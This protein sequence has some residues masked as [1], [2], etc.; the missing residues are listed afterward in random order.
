VEFTGEQEPTCAKDANGRLWFAT[1]KG[2]AM[3]DPARLRLNSHPP[4]VTIEEVIY[5]A[6]SE[7]EAEQGKTERRAQAPFPERLDLPAG[8]RN[9]EIHY[10][11]PSFTSPEKVRFQTRLQSRGPQWRDV[12]NR[13]V[14][15][16]DELRPGQNLFQ[17]R[18]ANDDGVWN[19]TGASL[20]FGVAPLF[21][22]TAWFRALAWVAVG[23]ETVLVIAL[24][25]A[26]QRR[27]RAR[28]ELR[29]RLHFE[30]LI[31]QLSRVF[32]NL[33]S[34]KIEAQ[35]KEAL[36][37]VG[38][39]LKFDIAAFSTLRGAGLERR[40]S[41]LWRHPGV[42][43]V[44]CAGLEEELPWSA[45]ELTQGRDV[46]LPSISRL[47]P[48][49]ETDRAAYA[50][51]GVQSS[52]Q[53]PLYAGGTVLAAFSLCAVRERRELTREVLQRQRLIGE[54]FVNAL[55]RK[56]AEDRQRESEARFRI[57]AD[58]APVMIWMSGVDKLCTFFNKTWLDF[59]GRRLEQELG[60]GWAEG[61]HRADL[62]RCLQAYA[63]AF[64][65]RKPFVLQYRLRRN[66]GEYRWIADN[67]LPRFDTDGD[68][69]GYIGSCTDFTERKQA[70]EKFRLAVET[71]PN[72][73]LLVDEQGRIVMANPQTEAMFGYSAEEL[74]GQ[75]MEI[76]VPERFRGR[77]PAYRQEFHASP[78]TRAMGKGRELFARRKDGSE[79]EVEIALNP[80][81]AQDEMLVLATIVDVTERRRANLE[82]QTLRQELAHAG[83][84]SMM[85]QLASSL[86]HE[87]NQPLGAILRNAEAAELFLK[88]GN[89][90]L[91]EVRAILV[92]IQKDDH[93]AGDV[94]DRMRGLLSRRKLE[95]TPMNV[96]ELVDEV[97]ALIRPDAIHRR[98]H[99]SSEVPGNLGPVLVNRVHLQQVLLN[100]LLN[101][102]D[103]MSETPQ[104]E[105][106]LVVTA[107][108]ADGQWIEVCVR[109]TGPGIPEA[110]LPSL[111]EPFYTTKPQGLGIGLPIS[112]TIIEAH[113]GKL[114]AEN[115]PERGAMFRFTL[116]IVNGGQ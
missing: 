114:W 66:D 21:W 92:D 30:Q 63:E 101:A 109:D 100:L 48:E 29:D 18:A 26:M 6:G 112:R 102:M 11:A 105:R 7:F 23:L 64:D 82:M 34:E 86:A 8:S 39:D 76:L 12:G 45:G 17:V 115:H 111:F 89:P 90:D 14:A 70:E 46:W 51:F 60:N 99:L 20:A 32:I 106:Q 93:R 13:R 37:K 85:G 61:V 94:I 107:Q 67:G 87:L 91:D 113:G 83:R 68:F 15:Y 33:P 69:A 52:Y 62:Q 95:R 38:E 55:T 71:S 40:I 98:V 41:I 88:K 9:I 59:T 108:Q 116:P 58:S 35:I 73:I 28:L 72:A 77:H 65:A 56:L 5:H 57:V 24:L 81:H 19:E 3:V 43:E 4:P 47:P 79:V 25:R 110:R 104:Q 2:V 80:I 74:G 75:S 31:S 49:A 10:T 54:V 1:L 27:R 50:K 53:V 96:R 22:Q 44:S 84:V 16:F 42:K 78:Q 36:R 97:L 103:A